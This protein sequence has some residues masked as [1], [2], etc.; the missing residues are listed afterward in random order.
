MLCAVQFV[1]AKS[2]LLGCC[3]LHRYQLFR[4]GK[5]LMMLGDAGGFKLVSSNSTGSSLRGRLGM[6]PLPGSTQVLDRASGQLVPCTQERCPLAVMLPARG[7]TQATQANGRSSGGSGSDTSVSGGGGGSGGS[8]DNQANSRSL[9]SSG[10]GNRASSSAGI[11]GSSTSITNATISKDIGSSGS[12]GSSTGVASPA[13]T[14][15][16]STGGTGDAFATASTAAPSES[17]TLLNRPQPVASIM[18]AVNQRGNPLSQFYTYNAL[19]TAF[20]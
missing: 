8:S 12:S 15:A 13:D 9:L 7:T 16:S 14:D 10:A 2:H 3:A 1:D 4:Q 17:Q 6:A 19:A 20:R 18:F 11:D 5:C